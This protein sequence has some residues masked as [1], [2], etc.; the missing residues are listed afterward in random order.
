[1]EIFP[2]IVLGDVVSFSVFDNVKAVIPTKF[3]NVQ[4]VAVLDADTAKSLIDPYSLHRNIFPLLE[5][6]T[7]TDDP[8]GY[9]Y[10]KVKLPNGKY[11][12][13]GYPWINQTTIEKRDAST[14]Q[15]LISGISSTELQRFKDHVAAG[16][17]TVLEA[18]MV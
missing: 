1:M 13:V 8:Y 4:I 10:I 2:G 9:T 15:V 11:T 16:G 18:K 14:A 12:A 17:W 6:G 5:D 7:V 3:E